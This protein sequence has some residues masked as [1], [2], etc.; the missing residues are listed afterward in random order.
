MQ[1]C[2]LCVAHLPEDGGTPASPVSFVD[3][4]REAR[5]A[6]EDARR[7]AR[8]EEETADT[9][10]TGSDEQSVT[11]LSTLS[12]PTGH[13]PLTDAKPKPRR[14]TTI[15]QM[16]AAAAISSNTANESS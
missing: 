16:L 6:A 9:V 1:Q 13:P 8:P 14:N 4:V 10:A 3:L 2:A 15:L 7:R 12:T 5:S 11:N